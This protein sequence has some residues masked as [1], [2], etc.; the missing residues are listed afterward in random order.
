LLLSLSLNLIQK[1]NDISKLWDHMQKEQVRIHVKPCRLFA[2]LYQGKTEGQF[3]ENS[4]TKSSLSTS[5]STSTSSKSHSGTVAT[6]ASAVNEMEDAKFAERYI[7]EIAPPAKM[8]EYQAIAEQQ[9][10]AL[11]KETQTLQQRFSEDLLVSMQLERTVMGISKMVTDFATLLESQAP[12]VEDIGE[13]AKDV[14][15]SMKSADAEL[16]LTLERTQ[17]QNWNM[18]TLVFVLSGLLLFFHFITP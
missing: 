8:R 12:M 3:I 10:A 13:V 2:H 6:S 17:S 15:A 7:D 5:A 18:I 14:K 16:L 11:F 1:L 4:K 9:R